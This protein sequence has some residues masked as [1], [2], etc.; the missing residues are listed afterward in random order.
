MTRRPSTASG[1]II[2][3]V[4][5]VAA[6][7]G[8]DPARVCADAD[9]AYDELER[10]GVRVPERA[11]TRL[12]DAMEEQTGDAAIGVHLAERAAAGTW[13]VLAYAVRSCATLEDA[14][15]RVRR[16]LPLLFTGSD[17]IVD[18]V[19]DRGVRT[20]GY[21]RLPGG[22]PL[23]PASEDCVVASFVLACR[24]AFGTPLRPVSVL[25]QRSAPAD[26][27]EHRRVLGCP[28]VFE[29]A[30]NGVALP[31][32]VWRAPLATHDPHL[33]ALLDGVAEAKLAAITTD[34]TLAQLVA[35]WIERRIDAR[36]PIGVEHAARAFRCSVRSFQRSL[37]SDETSYRALVDDARRRIALARV[38]DVN[39]KE[40]AVDLG[41]ADTTHLYRAF[42][43][44]TGR[45]IADYRR[46]E[47]PPDGAQAQHSGASGS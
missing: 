2:R 41:F 33:L 18:V 20:C 12:W 42:L 24:E 46:V 13:G 40:L 25:F 36:A 8:V 27:S 31:V 34:A 38:H 44:W 23:V 16:Y 32:D 45:T 43:R 14:W 15:D 35:A 4:V 5:D 22:N 9:I 10:E 7:L 47:V 21:R 3:A 6:T 28:V 29:A 1:A 39:A 11:V 37:A 17:E 30:L 26:D 19:D